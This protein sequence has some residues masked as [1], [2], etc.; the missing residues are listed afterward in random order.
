MIHKILSLTILTLLLGSCSYLDIVP[1][2]RPT[3]KDAFKDRYA[4]E[5]FLYSCYSFIPT[6][7]D[8]T[9]SLDLF[10]ADEVV[11]AFEHET[12]AGFPKGNYTASNPIISYWNTLF[13]GI[14][15]CYILLQNVDNTPDLAVEDKL[16]Y[17]AEAKFLIA[18]Y[19]FLLIRS[20]GPSIII[21]ELPDINTS[22]ANF[23]ARSSYDD[24][25]GFVGNLLDEAAAE[26]PLKYVSDANYGRAT[27]IAAKAI[28][29]RMLLYA[30]SP[31]FNG[32]G[33]NGTSFYNG[34]VNKDG[35]QLISTTYDKNKWKKAADACLE[36][37]N[38]AEANGF[39]LYTY[40]AAQN[41]PQPAD[42]IENQ[43]RYTFIDRQSKEI[44]WA[45]TRQEGYY[46]FQ[47]KS[48]PQ[49]SGIGNA[50]NGVAPTLFMLEQFYT[51]NGLPID[52]DP[53]F[54]YANRYSIST[55]PGTT[56]TT[57]KENL[58]REPRFNAWI[59]YHNGPYEIVR[60]SNRVITTKFRLKD[61]QG[62][63]GLSATK[64]RTNNYSPTGYLNKKGVVPQ[65]EQ[66]SSGLIQ[67]AWPVI[68]L[69]ELYLNYAEALIENGDPGDFA[70]AR[71]YINRVRIR[72]GIPTIENA[73]AL[74]PGANINDQETLRSIVRQE[75]TIELY[76]E[77]HRFWDVRRWMVADKFL[78]NKIYGMNIYGETDANFFKKT[79][80][81]VQRQFR[82]PANYLMPLPLQ[83]LNNNEKL[84]QNP[85]Y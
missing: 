19:H 28:K 76:L 24:C 52:K 53:S 42:P 8:G 31:L 75:R 45:D 78:G 64:P 67:Y 43:I 22:P 63:Q 27:K 69:A 26:L 37:I 82:T 84:V 73:W 1:D 7:R 18:Y 58:N 81:V 12:F 30:A 79:E 3:E 21:K 41:Q 10:T 32:G 48:T 17:K 36:A 83:D 62:I 80:V 77:N 14:R 25:V 71:E 5:R 20:Y 4:A 6:L 11:T 68:R 44:I 46:S 51:V 9:G 61:D 34:F 65:Y 35:T 49:A 23:P 59:A 2:E 50:W 47:N 54:D 16:G 85:G 40:N 13:G 39:R 74:V 55:I 38:L 66:A 29:A 70:T 15:Q 33:Q 57:L 56:K 72:A 60:G